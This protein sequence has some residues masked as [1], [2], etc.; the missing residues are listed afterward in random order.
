MNGDDNDKFAY[1]HDHERD[2]T[3]IPGRKRRDLEAWPKQ[4]A[5]ISTADNTRMVQDGFD[6]SVR[7]SYYFK[8]ACQNCRACLPAR[9][10]AKDYKFSR[11]DRKMM[12]RNADLVVSVN[13]AP[14]PIEHERLYTSNFRDRH[15]NSYTLMQQIVILHM[16]PIQ[17]MLSHQMYPNKVME[18]REPSKN[19][20]MPGRLIGAVIY[21]ECDDG[22][23]GLYYYYE[24]GLPA[25]RSLGNYM[26]LK[27]IEKAQ[28]DGK[29]YLYTGPLTRK[30]S[31]LA[32]KTRFQPLE[33]LG[34]K[35]WEPF[36]P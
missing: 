33:T 25:G 11:H 22:F 35:G 32:Y 19:P 29:P 13:P 26:I 8:L 30:P 18:I 10:V 4:G 28:A 12:H 27:L 24:P 2:C 31:R 20:H 7:L 36:K 17:R 14:N 1:E 9:I 5:Q 16:V 21:D 3:I 15:T 6:K 34:P 23:K